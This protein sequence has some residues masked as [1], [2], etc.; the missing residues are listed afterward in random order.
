MCGIWGISYGPGGPDA[1]MW[2]PAELAQLMFPAIVH[3]GPHSW[4]IMSCSGDEDAI[5]TFKMVGRCDTKA[6]LA[7]MDTVVPSDIKW[8]VGHV[9]YATHGKP[10]NLANDHPIHHG[11]IIGVHNG[12]LRHGWQE[13]L[14]ETGREDDSAEVDSEAIFAAVNKWG[15][16]AGLARINGDMVAVFTSTDNPAVLRIARSFGRPLVY[17]FTPAGSMVFASECKVLTATGMDYSTPIDFAGKYRMLS[18]RG[19]KITRREQ[20]RSQSWTK[21]EGGSRGITDYFESQRA[22]RTPAP[23]GR[24]PD[25]LAPPPRDWMKPPAGV[26]NGHPIRHVSVANAPAPRATGRQHGKQTSLGAVNIGGGWWQLPNGQV[27]DANEY[28]EWAVEQRKNPG[29]QSY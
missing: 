15:P 4:G 20:Y 12:V 1:E 23:G 19:G 22:E 29:K 28:I 26:V 13:V 6:A 11:K 7:E 9:R 2:T 8:L 17:A 18:V 3:R 27:I 24:K 14:A 5:D 16:K 21:F 10:D 25:A